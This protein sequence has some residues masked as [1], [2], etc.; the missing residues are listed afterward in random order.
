[1]SQNPRIA[2][3]T[4]CLRRV[5]AEQKRVSLARF[6][7]ATEKVLTGKEATEIFDY[8][9]SIK[10]ALIPSTQRMYIWK[11]SQDFFNNQFVEELCKEINLRE[12]KDERHPRP[13]SIKTSE[14]EQPKRSVVLNMS[15]DELVEAIEL[16]GWE[17]T[18]K[19]IR[20]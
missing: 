2:G 10:V 13:K 17:V 3:I 18:L 14:P 20:K 1:M 8:I 4:S 12:K 6:K 16:L 15:L 7:K 9:T 5:Y 11:C 19:H